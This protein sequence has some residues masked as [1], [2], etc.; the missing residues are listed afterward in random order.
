MSKGCSVGFEFY[1]LWGGIYSLA[2][3]LIRTP[4]NWI[5]SGPPCY[6]NEWAFAVLNVHMEH[7][8]ALNNVLLWRSFVMRY[9]SRTLLMCTSLNG[10]SA[11]YLTTKFPNVTATEIITATICARVYFNVKSNKGI[12]LLYIVL[13]LQGLVSAACNVKPMYQNVQLQQKP[14]AVA[15][16]FLYHERNVFVFE[17][18]LDLREWTFMCTSGRGFAL[19]VLPL[20]MYLVRFPARYI[21]NFYSNTLFQLN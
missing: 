16:L 3:P 11:Y 5:S 6:S 9:Y 15:D 18:A 12:P 17:Y 4:L 1:W 21:L 7:K 10:N 20:N 13:I 8:D 19:S 2:P 14:L